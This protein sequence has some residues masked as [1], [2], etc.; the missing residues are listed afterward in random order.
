MDDVWHRISYKGATANGLLLT[1]AS[2]ATGSP[3]FSGHFPGEPILPGVAI[4]A[5]VA[6]AVRHHAAETGRRIR[7]AN[8]RKVRFRLPVRPDEV[9]T[10]SLSFS[11]EE[12]GFSYHFRVESAGKMICTGIVTAK[13]LPSERTG[14]EAFS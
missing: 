9:M 1:E 2:A 10:I 7:I 13:T 6:D 12:E 3:W 5:M 4:L 11:P 14:Q 8:I